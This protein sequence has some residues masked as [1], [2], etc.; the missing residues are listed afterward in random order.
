MSDCIFCKI[1]N[2]EIPSKKIYEDE[3]IFAFLDIQPK[4]AG[5]TLVIPK[6]HF[7]NIYD[8]PEN[9]LCEVMKVVKILSKRINERLS[10]NGIYVRQNNGESVG[11]SVFHYHVHIIP[12]YE[13]EPSEDI[14]NIL[15]H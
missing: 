4:S 3:N 15:T 12:N 7:E 6:K 2:G 14:L 11:Q 5:H 10:P 8:I 9:T 1:V 13:K